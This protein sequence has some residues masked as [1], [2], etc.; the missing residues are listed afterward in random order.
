MTPI[1]TRISIG[2]AKPLRFLHVTD[3][4]LI[5]ADERDSDRKRELA[6]QRREAYDKHG[7]DCCRRGLDAAL[8]YARRQNELVLHTGDLIDFVS[9]RNL[10]LAR[11]KLSTVD[12]F[13]AAGNHE[14]SK[15]VGEAQED[16]AYKLDSLP[17]VASAFPNDLRFA[18]RLVGGVNL[19]AIDNTYGQVRHQELERFRAEIAKGYPILL[20]LHVPLYTRELYREQIEV[21]KAES[22]SLMGCPAEHPAWNDA[23]CPD[24]DTLAFID[25]LKRQTLVKAVLAGHLHYDWEGPLYGDV[26]QYVTAGSF[27][28]RA[29]EIEVA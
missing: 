10:E 28:G 14:F 18:A 13:F 25:F 12:C 11:E 16:E 17:L 23:Q 5:S 4:H 29:R 22:A 27:L 7:F 3:S 20:L 26:T 1:H 24:A 15:Y 6:R 9:Y 19:V 2:V 21:R 8:D